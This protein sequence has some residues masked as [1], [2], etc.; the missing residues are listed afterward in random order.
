MSNPQERRFCMFGNKLK[1]QRKKRNMTVEVLAE[2][3]NVHSNTVYRWENGVHMPDF[4][5]MK[6]IASILKC[7]MI[8]LL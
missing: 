7:K 6:R 3:V 2:M 8:D 4:Y 1:E 5:T